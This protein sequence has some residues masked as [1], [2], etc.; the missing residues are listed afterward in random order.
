M[1]NHQTTDIT[2]RNPQFKYNNSDKKMAL[3]GANRGG[4]KVT[5]GMANGQNAQNKYKTKKLENQWW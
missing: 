4:I 5:C 2:P 3:L 1:T